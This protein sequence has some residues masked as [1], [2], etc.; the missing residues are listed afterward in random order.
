M[1][2]APDSVQPSGLR[3]GRGGLHTHY[4]PLQET[5]LDRVQAV[6]PIADCT[7]QSPEKLEG[8]EEVLGAY[9]KPW[10]RLKLLLSH[11]PTHSPSIVIDLPG[12]FFPAPLL[13][14]SMAG[15]TVYTMR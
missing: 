13:R 12:I 3:N 10:E 1:L 14:L 5:L 8:A 6:R 11:L 15:L 7:L 9:A 4:Y 2:G